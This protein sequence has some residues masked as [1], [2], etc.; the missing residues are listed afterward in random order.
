MT[1]W[2]SRSQLQ[3]VDPVLD[4]RDHRLDHT[5][6]VHVEPHSRLRARQICMYCQLAGCTVWIALVMVPYTHMLG[7]S[8]LS[9]RRVKQEHWCENCDV[10]YP[11]SRYGH[12]SQQ[13]RKILRLMT[14]YWTE[15]LSTLALNGQMPPS[16]DL[17]GYKIW[18]LDENLK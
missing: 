5:D 2:Q 11:I 7:D 18:P 15:T 8:C 3:A 4:H 13:S 16:P 9:S 17:K 10:A 12:R 1:T 6:A 14:P